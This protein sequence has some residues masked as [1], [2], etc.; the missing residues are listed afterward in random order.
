MS[1]IVKPSWISSEAGYHSVDC[2]FRLSDHND[3]YLFLSVSAPVV[4]D[5][6]VAC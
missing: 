6:L 4:L 5:Y 1:N 2:H 3:L